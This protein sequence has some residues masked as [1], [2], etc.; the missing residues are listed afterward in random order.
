MK[1][2]V[3][4]WHAFQA[5]PPSPSSPGGGRGRGEEHHLQRLG[6][7]P[8]P[9]GRGRSR[10]LLASPSPSAAAAA[11]LCRRRGRRG[12]MRTVGRSEPRQHHGVRLGHV[13]LALLPVPCQRGPLW[14]Q[15]F[16]L[17]GRWKQVSS[18]KK[19]KILTWW[20]CVSPV[21]C[22]ESNAALRTGSLLVI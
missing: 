8:Q 11:S 5:T 13:L 15:R 14:E 16:R 10:F 12:L 20:R 7:E 21:F 1:G 17:L 18:L 22:V 19:K 4:M 6:G 3:P 9:G 2:S